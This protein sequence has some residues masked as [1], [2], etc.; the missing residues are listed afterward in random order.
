VCAR[1]DG[2]PLA[3]ELAAARVAALTPAELTR[4]LNLRSLTR[5]GGSVERHET[6]QAAIGWSYELLTGP[7]QRLLN[8]LTVFAGG[9]TLDAA[10]AICAGELVKHDEVID[11][12]T[13]LVARSLVVA[14][15]AGPETR[16]RLLETI[17][18]YGDERLIEAAETDTLRARHADYYANFANHARLNITGPMQVE[19]AARLACEHDNL[20]TAMTFA[21]RTNDLERAMRLFCCL[22]ESNLQI[23]DLVVFDPAPL[24]ALRGASHHPGF[25]RVLAVS[26]HNA[27]RK[28]EPSLAL[29]LADQALDAEQRLGPYPDQ[30]VDAAVSQLRSLVA[31][32]QGH[33]AEAASIGLLAARQ[34]HAAGQTA[35]EALALAGTASILAWVEPSTA[36]AHATAALALARGSGMPT[37]VAMSSLALAE[38]LALTDP[39]RAAALLRA[40]EPETN[41]NTNEVFHLGFAAGLIADWPLALRAASRLLTLDRRSGTMSTLYL[42]GISNFVARGLAEDQPTPAAVIQGAVRGLL[43]RSAAETSTPPAAG[44]AQSDLRAHFLTRTHRETTQLL[45]ERLGDANVRDLRARGE[46]MDRDQACAFALSHVDQYLAD[47]SQAVI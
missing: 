25:A 17:R 29:E 36:A 38:A 9:C 24:L 5:R 1:L 27:F 39:D 28:G 14:D 2:L 21:L 34:A 19:W 10:T 42:A 8:R 33:L 47:S 11:I 32:N 46:A 35:R 16:Y 40:Q 45:R 43:R 6:L 26:A 44:T 20:Q 30:Y 22:P 37:A 31:Q 7:E 18:Q 15:T 4:H 3:I 23:D 12:L 41:D 13:S